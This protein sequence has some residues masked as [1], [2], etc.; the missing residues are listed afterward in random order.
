[1]GRKE[2]YR[3]KIYTE[4]CDTLSGK[5]K[6]WRKEERDW[7][8]KERKKGRRNWENWILTYDLIEFTD[9]AARLSHETI[10]NITYTR[11]ICKVIFILGNYCKDREELTHARQRHMTH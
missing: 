5:L 1:M 4:C 11:D 3:D 9:I 6:K 2:L 10:Y 8:K 7:K